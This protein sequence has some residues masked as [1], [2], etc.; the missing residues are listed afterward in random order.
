MTNHIFD[1]SNE[2]ATNN[3]NKTKRKIIDEGTLHGFK[4]YV[5]LNAFEETIVYIILKEK[6]LYFDIPYKKGITDVLNPGEYPSNMHEAI[7]VH[8]FG[9]TPSIGN[10]VF[11]TPELVLS[12]AMNSSLSWAKPKHYTKKETME[13]IEKI[14]SRLLKYEMK[15]KLAGK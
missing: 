7:I 6:D 10:L 2:S 8:W 13:Y 4:Y 9:V 12:T 15:M 14:T 3:I 5:G 11:Q 1:K